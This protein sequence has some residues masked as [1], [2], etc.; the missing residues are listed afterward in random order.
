MKRTI[1]FGLE[2]KMLHAR[3]ALTQIQKTFS[4]VHNVCHDWRRTYQK[5]PMLRHK[6]SKDGTAG[7]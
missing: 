6:L 7:Q 5:S 2:V 3:R 4:L 1:V